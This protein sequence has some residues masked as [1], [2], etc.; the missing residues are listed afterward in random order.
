MLP[1]PILL[2]S[3]N[4]KLSPMKS[5]ISRL[6]AAALFCST[7][8][9]GALPAHA[10]MTLV[11]HWTL[12]E[13]SGS[14]AD[15][16]GTNTL[17]SVNSTTSVTGQVGNAATFPLANSTYLTIPD[18]ASLST[19]GAN[20]FK[21]TLW[22][23]LIAKT[24]TQVFVS[25]YDASGQGE[26]AV[27][28]EHS[29]RRFVF[30]TYGSA[31]GNYFVKADTLGEPSVDTWYQ[32]EVEHNGQT[33][34]NSIKVNGGAANI[35]TSVPQHQDT[36]APFRI[37]AFGPTPT[38]FA[39]A[40]ID[41]VKFYKSAP[42]DIPSDLLAY[43]KFDEGTGSTA[44]DW[45]RGDHNGTIVGGA[46]YSSSVPTVDFT[47]PYSLNL[48]GSND[49]VNTSLSLNGSAAFTLAGW[50]YPRSASNGM[51]WF[52]A[53][54]VFEF[55]FSGSNSLRCWTPSGSV[56]WT[57]NPSTF[58]NNWHHITC[59][60][61]GS[62]II[63]Y[64]DGTQVASSAHT[65]TN[66]YGSGDT[67][68]IGIGVQNGG[69]NGP[70]DGMIDDV[71]VY[72]RALS[73]GEMLSLGT[74][75]ETPTEAPVI[76]SLTPDNGDT[77][78][79]LDATPAVTFSTGSIVAGSGD[80][81]IYTADD[82]QLVEELPV[83]GPA[84]SISGSTVTITPTDPFEENTEYYVMIPNTA[85]EDGSGNFYEGTTTSTWHF[86]TGDFTVPEITDLSVTTTE[87]SAVI[88]WTTSEIASSFVSYGFANPNDFDTDET[89]TSPR[90]ISHEVELTDLVA[91]TTYFYTV[92]SV[93]AGFNDVVSDQQ[94]FTTAG[95]AY[96]AEPL[97]VE[98]GELDSADG[99]DFELTTDDDKT[100][101][102]SFPV[103]T[104]SESDSFVVQIKILASDPV[105]SSIGRPHRSLDEVGVNVFDVKAIINNDTILDSFNAPVTITYQ[106]T[107]EEIE[108]LDEHTLKLYHYTHG[109]WVMLDDCLLDQA[110]NTISCTTQSFSIFALFGSAPQ[111]VKAAG[112]SGTMFGC[113][114]PAATN[115][116]RFVAHKPELCHY[117][118]TSLSTVRDL[119][120]G[121]T[122]EDV[123]R[124]QQAL[125]ANGF[126]LGRSG[127]GSPGNETTYFGLRTKGAL[128]VF[129]KKYGVS[130]TAG[131]FGVRTRAAMKANNF[132]GLWW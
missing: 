9:F 113:K 117:S 52:G 111:V 32:I 88:T 51:S 107:D 15:S 57:F 84:I 39:N 40:A 6:L 104:T 22:V 93:D 75:A 28:Y 63:L 114:D 11:S 116:D 43:W 68:S 86:T 81:G 2:S 12:D 24:G 30:S 119:M 87:T 108:G 110:I 89:D 101:T 46:T 47:D 16:V 7:F 62:S 83:S 125:N 5:G 79:A 69:T 19:T 64:V 97:Q 3:P 10:D 56:D 60:G 44:L 96:E 98:A 34:T 112:V 99:G 20:N 82:D 8:F 122:G 23:K 42:V 33:N 130:P 70:F 27:Y 123:K 109:A 49:G 132:S 61:T 37:G 38:Y 102:V 54:N 67:F 124:L 121:M 14:R 50:G 126:V 58:L 128:A 13:A 1:L 35:V 55:F 94:T 73:P 21:I 53:N 74:G 120:L 36:A 65:F 90:V 91:C 31:G 26:Y 29:F 92:T 103:N 48:D 66:N 72:N 95:C 17:T 105:L 127:D 85:F 78:V 80:I 59:L 131:Y 4:A 25:K 100:F 41:E 18:N 77:D 118:T 45:A 129:Q 76:T 71:R 106:Y 115:Y